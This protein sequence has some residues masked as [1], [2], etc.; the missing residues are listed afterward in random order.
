MND[1]ELTFKCV[2]KIIQDDRE[3]YENYKSLKLKVK[4]IGDTYNLTSM[5]NPKGDWIDLRSRTNLAMT[6]GDFA[7]IPLGI[8]MQIPEG[9]EAIIAPRSSTFK[10]YGIIQ[11]NSIGVIDESYC[12]ENDEWMLPVYATRNTVIGF[13][14][15]ICQFR[16]FKH[17]PSINFEIG[18]F[19]GNVNRGG[20]GS[21]GVK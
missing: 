1:E 14:D 19:K 3:A 6:K 13:G 12:G 15:R 7:L 5:I 4:I 10:K 11:T 2:E 9:Y 21:T 16:L 8:V 17:Q 18:D 20:F